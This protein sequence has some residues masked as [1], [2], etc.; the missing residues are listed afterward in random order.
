MRTE[1]LDYELPPERI[2]QAPLSRRDA[3]RLLTLDRRDGRLGELRF[4]DLPEALGPD[5]L[6]VV[7]DTRVVPA[8]LRGRKGTG[9]VAEAL[10]LERRADGS[11]RALVRSRGRLRPGLELWFQEARARVISVEPDGAC[12]LCFETGEQGLLERIGEAPLPPYIR[13]E[14]A[15]KADLDDYQSVFARVPGAVAA[16][17]ASLHFTAELAARLPIATLTLHVGPGTFRPIRGEIETHV[18]VAERFSIPESTARAIAGTR[19]RG[20][21]VIAV[22]TTVVRALETTGGEAGS[23][24]T[25]LFVRPGHRFRVVDSLV[26]NFHLP[27]SS[28][29]ALVMAFA[30]VE[31]VRAAY[32]RAIEAGFRF[33]SYGDAMWIR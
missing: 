14:S 23:G 16:P 31:S 5:D 8:K 3:A 13:R 32:G 20:G 18:L 2:A 1:D 10:L 27:R 22:G 29:L 33:Y 17:T 28:L 25:S 30:G 15:R 24:E 12:S 26:T 7:N 11:W 4:A 19:E 9:G 21:R 6:L